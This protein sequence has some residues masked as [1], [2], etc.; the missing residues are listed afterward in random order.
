M[1]T[2]VLR[3]SK[4]FHHVL[5]PWDR[6]IPC[7]QP[8]G[9]V[10]FACGQHVVL[11]CRDTDELV[12]LLH[13]KHQLPRDSALHDF[14]AVTG[15]D[16]VSQFAGHS[17]VTEWKALKQNNQLLISLGCD[18]LT[19]ET[20]NFICNIYEPL[21]EITNID[22]MRV[23]MFNKGKDADSLPPTSEASKLHIGRAHYQTSVWLNAIVP[24][25]AITLKCTWWPLMQILTLYDV[26][27]L[28]NRAKSVQERQA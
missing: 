5:W 28:G 17:R 4:G 11:V 25:P 3:F 8:T 23:Y 1:P 20:L 19:A 13:F 14:H 2:G 10:R 24:S 22:Q 21:T 16:A 9:S 27:Q 15:C 26:T 18:E 12:F 7:A 6:K